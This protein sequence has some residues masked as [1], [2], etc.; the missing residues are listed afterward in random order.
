MEFALE[1]AFSNIAMGDQLKVSCRGQN[2]RNV[3][4]R[5]APAKMTDVEK[6]KKDA[7]KAAKPAEPKAAPVTK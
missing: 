5:V 7:P 4:I 1:K 3:L 6:P 2:G